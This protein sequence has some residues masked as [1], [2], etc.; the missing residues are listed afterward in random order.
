MRTLWIVVAPLALTGCS[1]LGM[2]GPAA[3]KKDPLADIQTEHDQLKLQ[4]ARRDDIYKEAITQLK[5]LVDDLTSRLTRAEHQGVVLQSLVDRLQTPMKP[6]TGGGVETVKGPAPEKPVPPTPTPP[7]TTPA[8]TPTPPVVTPT[9]T[10]AP[11]LTADKASRLAEIASILKD[12]KFKIT[13]ALKKELHAM[14]AEATA[15][16]FDEIKRDFRDIDFAQRVEDIVA[17]FPVDATR[18]PLERAL[19]DADLRLNALRAV[20]RYGHESWGEALKA[21][22]ANPDDVVQVNVGVA[23]VKS[24]EKCGIPLLIRALNSNDWA[25]RVLAINT[26]RRINRREDYAYAP[27]KS[28]EENTDAVKKWEAW[29]EAFK[30][31]DLLN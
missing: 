3:D 13:D 18:A 10:P 14:P 9:V 22:M 27:F 26:L 7:T 2:G 23:L 8:V 24:K 11:K 20:A 16:F 17:A 19:N 12:P 21:Q 5:N 28:A 31:A 30:D 15:F 4:M 6:S 1:M 25:T 29:W